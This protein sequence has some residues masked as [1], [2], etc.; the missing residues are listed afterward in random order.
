MLSE[1]ESSMCVEV[2]FLLPTPLLHRVLRHALY[3]STL[4]RLELPLE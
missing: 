4:M 3:V 1:L 2:K